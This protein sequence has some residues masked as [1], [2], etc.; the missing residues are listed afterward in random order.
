MGLDITAYKQIQK[1]E[2][3]DD[4]GDFYV[5]GTDDLVDFHATINPDFKERAEDIEDNSC[6]SAVDSFGFKAGSYGGY[7][8]WRNSLAR[9]AGYK[10]VDGRFDSGAW[11][12]REGAFY[13]LINFSDCEGV[14]GSSVSK[15]LYQDFLSFDEKATQEGEYFYPT[16]INFM[17]AF[18]FASESGA[19]DFH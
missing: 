7:N 6:Y 17:T 10:K 13:E 12:S 5:K 1:V 16:Y 15:K 3:I 4:G 2:A 9:I 11:E 8:A 19:V 18:K 14:I